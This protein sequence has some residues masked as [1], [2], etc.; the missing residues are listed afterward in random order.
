MR[1][2]WRSSSS[3]NTTHMSPAN[4][5]RS[6][7][8]TQIMIFDDGSPLDGPD[9]TDRP[10]LRLSTGVASSNILTSWHR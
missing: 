4:P 8:P 7:E 2:E 5:K 6:V 1:H 9:A 3:P 10:T